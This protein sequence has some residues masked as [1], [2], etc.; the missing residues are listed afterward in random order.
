MP[1][2]RCGLSCRRGAGRQSRYHYINGTIRGAISRAEVPVTKKPIGFVP[3]D[4]KR[5]DDLTSA[6]WREGR[7]V[8]WNTTITY[9]VADSYLAATSIT[10]GAA[11]E[12]AAE[13]MTSKYAA[14]IQHH[15][16]AIESFGP[17]LC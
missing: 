6:P 11:A 12:A 7:S 5:P 1:L 3:A 15:M 13:R 10:A 9:T 16:L 4:G 2:W 14:L 17:Y 8:T